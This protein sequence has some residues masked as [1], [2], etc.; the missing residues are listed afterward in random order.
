MDPNLTQG[1]FL[2]AFSSLVLALHE[3]N[4]L[5]LD[6]LTESM[7]STLARRKVDLGQS[8]EEVAFALQLLTGLQRLKAVFPR[9]ST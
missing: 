3:N 2:D 1:Q 4:V 8:D 6:K 9:P 5:T 7:E